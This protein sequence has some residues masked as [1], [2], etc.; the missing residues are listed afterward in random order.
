MREEIGTLVNKIINAGLEL[1]ERLAGGE[2]PD[3]EKEQARL[4][5]LLGDPEGRRYHEFAGET[6]TEHSLMAGRSTTGG[7]RSSGDNFLGIRYALVCWL[8]EIFSL[9]APP[10]WSSRWS[11]ETLEVNLY[12]MR[13]RALNFWHQARKAETRPS[14]ALEAYFLCVMLGF[15]GDYR[16][17]P[18]RLQSWVSSA[19]A[20]ISK[21]QSQEWK[22]GEE[23]PAYTNV[24]PLWG[25]DKL[26]R[27]V[28]IGG[29]VVLL[30]ILAGSF[31]VVFGL[32]R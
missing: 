14:D 10:D 3:L 20:L 22:A 19:Y 11:E 16:D 27:M 25:R 23:L 31:Y 8:D 29:A 24:P 7:S 28:F 13:D 1:K 9:D 21:G 15:R 32:T 18:D 2:Q 12:G 5:G 6:G 26:Q 17:Q 30:L 4:K